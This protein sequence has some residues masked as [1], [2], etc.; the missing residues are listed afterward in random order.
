MDPGWCRIS[1]INSMTGRL[2]FV[3][4]L[5]ACNAFCATN[6]PTNLIGRGVVTLAE[7]WTLS[8]PWRSGSVRGGD[9]W[10]WFFRICVTSK[11]WGKDIVNH[12]G[13][14][15]LLRLFLGNVCK[16]VI[17]YPTSQAFF[18]NE[19]K[20]LSQSIFRWNLTP[21][22]LILPINFPGGLIGGK[23][24]IQATW[25]VTPSFVFRNPLG[26]PRKLVNGS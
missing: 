24:F 13:P 23:S 14:R 17:I 21:H 9:R 11:T 15:F 19:F 16:L 3:P 18:L 26:C 12:F 7:V 22:P 1:S 6:Q 4:N 5:A 25:Q 10:W 2:G 20:V 8:H